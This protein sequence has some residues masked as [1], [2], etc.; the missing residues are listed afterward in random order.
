MDSLNLLRKFKYCKKPKVIQEVL[1]AFYYNP[2]EVMIR[3]RDIDYVSMGNCKFYPTSNMETL[4]NPINNPW[5]FEG[6]KETD[7]VLDIGACIGSVTIPLAKVAKKV[8]SV[9]PLF[10]E[11][12][13]ANVELNNLS[14][15]TI[16]K[17]ALG[18]SGVGVEISYGGYTDFVESFSFK[19]LLTYIYIGEHIDFLKVDCEGAEW[20]INPM[21]LDS[22]REIRIEYHLLRR[23]YGDYCELL[24]LRR[25]ELK[26]MG[27][28]VEVVRNAHSNFSPKFKEVAYLKASKR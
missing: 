7:T 9:E 11:E 13:K 19:G 26:A 10:W 23:G 2:E 3:P 27:F 8:V 4:V 1:N 12:L 18:N 6:V 24:S 17:A 28:T 20:L 14:N 21:D 16:I 15:V 5:W 22:I 25:S